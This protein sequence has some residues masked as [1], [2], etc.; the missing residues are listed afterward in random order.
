MAEQREG[1]GTGSAV[2]AARDHA[3]AGPVVV[4]SGDQPLVTAALIADLVATQ[5]RNEASATLLT[6]DVLDPAGYGR[7]VRDADGEFERIVETK[8]S[9]EVPAD[10]LAIREINLGTYVFDA[11]ELFSALDEVG[12]GHGERYLT[13]VLPLLRERGR[14][15]V[16]H[17]TGDATSAVGVND[18][19]DLMAAEELAQRRILAAHAREGVTFLAP[20]EHPRGGGREHRRRRHDRARRVP[21]GRHQRGRRGHDRP[22][23]HPRRLRGGRAGRGRPHLRHAGERGGRRHGRPVRLPAARHRRRCGREGRHLRRGQELGHRRRRQ[24]PASVLHRRR[25][26][27][28]G[29]NLGASTITANYDGR[30]KHRTKVG[31]SAKTGIHTS[32]VAPVDVGERAYTGAGSVITEDVPEGA[33]GIARSKQSNVE[34]YADRVEEDSQ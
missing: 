9:E 16:T 5:A 31:K 26:R 1:E 2:L 18:R 28:R 15:V 33:L 30:R 17:L 20:G 10:E 12:G 8:Y 6:T 27:G 13:G 7:I 3:G 24:G 22:A 29:S 11:A 34:G 23:D 4:L 19:A 14:R 25:R 21:A 32:L